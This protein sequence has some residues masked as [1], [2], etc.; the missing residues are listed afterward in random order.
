MRILFDHCVPQ[1][2]RRLL[3][4]HDVRTAVEMGWER[5]RNGKLLAEASEQFD[6][7]LTVDKNLR[8]QQNPDTLPIAVIILM[9]RTNRY[10]DLAPLAPAVLKAIGEVQPQT[11]VEIAAP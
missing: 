8:H 9:V 10:S 1:R 2:F 3:A 4:G 7:F 6:L 5:L 11:F